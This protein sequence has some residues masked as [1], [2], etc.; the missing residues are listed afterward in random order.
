MALSDLLAIRVGRHFKQWI[1]GFRPRDGA[2]QARKLLLL[3]LAFPLE[4][5]GVILVKGDLAAIARAR[6]LNAA[7]LRNIRQ[8]LFFTFVYDPPGV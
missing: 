8:N 2:R 5:A 6:R 7:T 1:A 4:S 3:D